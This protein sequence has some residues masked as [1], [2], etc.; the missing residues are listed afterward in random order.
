M[1]IGEIVIKVESDM[2]EHVY[3][4]LEDEIRN[5]LESKGIKAE[6]FDAV[7]GN[8]TK[9]RKGIMGK[10]D[11]GMEDQNIKGELILGDK[12]WFNDDLRCRL[13]ICG[14]TKEQ[15]EKLKT[16]KFVDLT[17]TDFREDDMPGVAIYIGGCNR[18]DTRD[19]KK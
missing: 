12:I 1:A 5:L 11:D 8:T 14:W 17:L 18:E 2:T 6:I 10:N 15:I 9:T 7:T 4:V 19:R 3:E 16:A 13:R